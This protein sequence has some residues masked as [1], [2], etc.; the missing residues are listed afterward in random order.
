[1]PVKFTRHIGEKTIRT[2]VC[3]HCGKSV[4]TVELLESN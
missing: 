2:R 3:R 1:M 4:K